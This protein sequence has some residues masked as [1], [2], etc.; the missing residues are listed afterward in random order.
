[1]CPNHGVPRFCILLLQIT[2]DVYC[3]A[4]V[5]KIALHMHSAVAPRF[6]FYAW[7]V[8]VHT[9]PMLYTAVDQCCSCLFCLVNRGRTDA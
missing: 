4:F 1:M 2:E 5:A 7:L 6:V 3:D 9:D 8:I